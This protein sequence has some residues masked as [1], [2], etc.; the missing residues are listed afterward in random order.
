MS[1]KQTVKRVIIAAAAASVLYFS[2][3]ALVYRNYWVGLFWGTYLSWIPIYDIVKGPQQSMKTRAQYKAATEFIKERSLTPST[4]KFCPFAEAKFGILS[5]TGQD[6]M[7]AWV[8]MQNAFGAMIRSHFTAVFRKDD[9]RSVA[10]VQ[11][12]G[13]D[14]NVWR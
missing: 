13:E 10:I 1:L 6:A 8:D 2:A 12:A 14:E 7:E 9:P 3:V 5:A 11:W 4:A